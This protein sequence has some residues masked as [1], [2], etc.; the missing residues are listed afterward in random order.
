MPSLLRDGHAHACALT[1]VAASLTLAWPAA[2]RAAEIGLRGRTVPQ[3]LAA[4]EPRGVRFLF[5]SQLVSDELRVFDEPRASDDPVQVAR[6]ILAAHGLG[7]EAIQTGLYAVI[8]IGPPPART[9]AADTPAA[10]AEL[11][12]VMVSASRYQIGEPPSPVT[13]VSSETLTQ[14]PAL[15]ADPVRTLGRLPGFSRDGFSARAH[16]RGGEESEVLTLLDG[17]PLRDAVHLPG[18]GSFFSVFDAQLLRGATVF[19]GGFPALYGNRMSGVLDLHTIDAL[20]A[21]R[22]SLAVDFFNASARAGGELPSA[23]LDYLGLAR[24]GMLRPLLEMFEQDVS[25]PS[26]GDAYFRVGL[27][28]MDGLRVTANLLWARDELGIVDSERSEQAV[29]H[30]GRRYAWLRGDLAVNDELDLHLWAGQSQ[31]EATREGTV[32]QVGVV[33]GQVSDDRSASLYEA[34]GLGEWRVSDRLFLQSGFEV[35]DEHAAYRYHAAARYSPAARALFARDSVLARDLDLR[36]ARRR[37]A[38][39]ASNR[40][41]LSDTLTSEVGLRTQRLV[42]RGQESDWI[43]EPRASLRWQL[44]PRTDLRGSWGQFNQIDDVNELAIGD[45]VTRFPV[46]QRAEHFVLGAQHRL[47]AGWALRFEA[48]HKRQ[49]HPRVRY[50]NALD[51]QAILAEIAPDRIAL[52]PDSAHTH[53][54]ELTADYARDNLEASLSAS[55]SRSHDRFAGTSIPRS[56]DQPWGVSGSLAWTRGRW[57][58]SGAA[59]VHRGWPRTLLIAA[60]DG[61][62]RLGAR[63]GD[64]LPLFRQL[65][66]KVQRTQPLQLGELVYSLDVINAQ[67]RPNT[68]CTEIDVD[69]VSGQLRGRRAVWFPLIPSLGVRWNY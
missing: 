29:V 45:G 55:W 46:P 19:T 15:A 65:D 68:C 12:E 25:R 21:P 52:A 17:Y 41:R 33:E 31:L 60:P 48:F 37:L 66:L 14:A 62:S 24:I 50:E 22:R 69:P 63:N 13:V 40:W 35:T 47:S 57:L 59:E 54:A 51:P 23:G 61:S 43:S 11:S 3:A 9:P 67:I 34:R 4:L 2:L 8:R 64:R 6:E 42:T 7:L 10:P 38:L 1:F 39:F 44:A 18:Y 32:R 56:W 27:A 53:G 36:P 30:G 58:W 16:V 20:S 5:S 28:A 49:T 26:Y